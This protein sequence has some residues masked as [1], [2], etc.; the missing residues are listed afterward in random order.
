MSEIIV[1]TGP[2]AAQ[3][4][5]ARSPTHPP[6]LRRL[7]AGRARER[8]APSLSPKVLV[9]RTQF[10]QPARHVERNG[11]EH[12]RPRVFHVAPSRHGRLA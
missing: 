5:F 12:T 4:R 8:L 1:D 3:Q 11:G 2:L 6:W 7:A 10:H 9:E